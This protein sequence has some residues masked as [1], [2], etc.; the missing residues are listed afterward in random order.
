MKKIIY[1]GAL[2]LCVVIFGAL[3][4]NG[5]L[6]FNYPPKENYPVRGVDVSHYQGDI[7]WKT[8]SETGIKFAY[9]KATEGT[10]SEDE[11]FEANW[12]GAQESGL[13][14]GAYH[15]FSLD[16]GGAGQAGNFISNV[17]LVDNMLPPV[18]DVEPY[19][20]Y[21]DIENVDKEA[22]V[23]ELTTYVK[24]IEEAYGMKPVIYTTRKWEHF[25]EP[26][27]EGYDFWVRNVYFAPDADYEWTF[28]QY[29]NRTKL[30]GY[31]G[32]EKFIDMDVFNG[33][34]DEFEHYPNK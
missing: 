30:D 15:F 10:L 21:T 31:S 13:R 20:R 33:T 3:F 23:A 16:S 28:W 6:Q 8:L 19:G 22:V 27:F 34:L 25:I 9:I 5:T 7:D 14:V 1:A 12:A 26:A 18:V 29:S 11:C 24:A 32:E 4:T 17:P 2:A